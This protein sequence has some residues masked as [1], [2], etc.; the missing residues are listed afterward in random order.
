MANVITGLRI[1]TSLALLFCPVFS[2]IFYTLYLISGL[3]D[4]AVC[5]DGGYRVDQDHQHYIRDSQTEEIC[6]SSYDYEQGDRR[7]A[8][9]I[10]TDI[11][12]SSA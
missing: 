10:A 2:P 8:I 5:M 6:R 3:S 7:A 12:N 11:I 1:L 4:M 9:H